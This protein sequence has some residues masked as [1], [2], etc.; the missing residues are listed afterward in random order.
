MN[1]NLPEPLDEAVTEA[2]SRLDHDRA[3]ERLWKRDHT[4]WSPDP[5]EIS[6]RLG[7]LDITEPE[8]PL[9]RVAAIVEEAHSEEVAH[10]VLLGM[11]GSSLGAEALA[12]TFGPQQGY[13]ELLVLDSTV[14]DRVRQVRSA[15]EPRRT[16]FITASKSGGT[17]E[18]SALFDYFWGEVTSGSDDPGRRFLAIT[19]PGTSLA[20]LAVER[21]FRDVFLNPPDVGGRFSVLTLFGVVPAA[22]AGIDMRR[23]IARAERMRRACGPQHT[24]EANPGIALGAYLAA[25]AKHGRDKATLLVPRRVAAFGLWAEQLIAESTGKQGKGI[26]PVAGEPLVAPEA[27]GDDRAFVHL[28]LASEPDAEVEA[29]AARLRAAGQPVWDLKLAHAWDL[30]AQFFLW[31]VATALAG[32][33]LELHPFDQPNVESAKKSTREVLAAWERTGSLPAVEVPSDLAAEL[34]RERPSYVAILAYLGQDPGLESAVASLR[35]TLVE[36]FH[37][38]T[39]FGYGPRYLHSTGQLHKGGPP[40]G[41]HVELVPRAMADL[42]IPGRRYGLATLAAAQADGDLLALQ[43]AG[44]RCVRLT[45]GDPPADLARMARELQLG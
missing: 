26:L 13:P 32:H 39:T 28:R 19:D 44:R 29:H 14:P 37:V 43:K 9:R 45:L 35:S 3:V 8:E 11:G 25:A 38:A 1:E 23:L 12:A 40:G 27:Y 2:I 20:Q 7:W 15:I 21:G 33:L 22:L 24:G 16:L 31:Q 36:R 18:V 6:D 17:A 5:R 42:P 34:R 10:I 41:L 30:G 4:L